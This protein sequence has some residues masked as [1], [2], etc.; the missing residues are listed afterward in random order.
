VGSAAPAAGGSAPRSSLDPFTQLLAEAVLGAGSANPVSLLLAGLGA[1]KNDGTPLTSSAA[2]KHPAQALLLHQLVGP[3]LQ[4]MLPLLGLA[5]AG[6]RDTSSSKRDEEM[7][8]LRRTI[9]QQQE[10]IDGLHARVA[11]IKPTK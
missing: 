9:Q 5:M 1:R 10:A 7:S 6:S 2:I 8:E 3:A 11:K 4:P